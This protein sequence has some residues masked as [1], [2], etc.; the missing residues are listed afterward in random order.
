YFDDNSPDGKLG[1]LASAIT[2]ALIDELSRVQALSVISK[3]GVL[4]YRNANLPLD[5]I[6]RALHVGSMVGGSVERSGE[7]VRIRVSLIDPASGRTLYANT[8]T[9]PMGEEFALI[10]GVV[11]E[12][13][14]ALRTRLGKE[15]ELKHWEAGTDNVQAWNVVKNADEMRSD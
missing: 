9:K 1:Y 15:I 12:V 2:T 5:S 11:Q 10:D 6:G 8:I 14:E 4:P 3:N 13:S 7:Q